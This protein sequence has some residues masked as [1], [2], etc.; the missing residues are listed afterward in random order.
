MKLNLNDAFNLLGISAGHVT[1]DDIKKAYRKAAQK[2]HPD[3]NPAGLEMMQA[4]N[5]AY[6]LLK[7]YCGEVSPQGNN[8]DYGDQLNAALNAIMGLGLIIEIC[9]AWIWV[10]GDTFP[11]QETLNKAKFIW[12][13]PKKAWYFC[14]TGSKSRRRR[15][16]GWSMAKIRQKY[17]SEFIADKHSAL[18][19]A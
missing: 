19:T 16:K 15:H 14:P 11:H 17:G 1:P 10:R 4:I 9:G 7:D 8:K 6:D 18:L 5:A 3:K 13:R 2:Y 12:S